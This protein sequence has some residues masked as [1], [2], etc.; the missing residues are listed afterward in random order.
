MSILIDGNPTQE[1]RL[2]PGA[3]F[4]E[5]GPF[6][7]IMAWEGTWAAK[8]DRPCEKGLLWALSSPWNR[9]FL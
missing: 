9:E 4:V 3:R 7:E 2:E 6:L 8:G 5:F 1:A